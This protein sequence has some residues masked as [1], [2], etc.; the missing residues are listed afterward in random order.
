MTYAETVAF[1]AVVGDIDT[2]E[3]DVVDESGCVAVEVIGIFSSW[4]EKRNRQSLTP[5][6]QNIRK[7]EEKRGRENVPDNKSFQANS[8]PSLNSRTFRPSDGSALV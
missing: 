4:Q 6:N 5:S 8:Q 1:N 3:D 7:H 2:E